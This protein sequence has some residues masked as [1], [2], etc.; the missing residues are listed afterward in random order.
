MAVLLSALK[1][2]LFGIKDD[3]PMATGVV[4]GVLLGGGGVY[5]TLKF[6]FTDGRSPLLSALPLAT[7]DA[8][9]ADRDRYKAEV[10]RLRSQLKVS[11]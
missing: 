5:Y 7:K 6:Y 1:D 3:H 10:Q 2:F 8:L 4:I 9:E 11:G